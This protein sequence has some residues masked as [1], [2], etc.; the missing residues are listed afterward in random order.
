MANAVEEHEAA[1]VPPSS[2]AP[3][4][5]V[6]IDEVPTEPATSPRSQVVEVPVHPRY[7]EE[8]RLPSREYGPH[9]EPER[10]VTRWISRE[11]ETQEEWD[12][13]FRKFRQAWSNEDMERERQQAEAAEY[14]AHQRSIQ[15]WEAKVKARELD[16][17]A[18][19]CGPTP[20]GTSSMRALPNVHEALRQNDPKMTSYSQP[21]VKKAPPTLG[22]ARPSAFYSDAEPPRIGAPVQPPPPA[23]PRPVVAP[24]V[25][26]P[27]A[28]TP[29]T[30][31]HPP[32]P[33]L[34]ALPKYS[35]METSSCANKHPLEPPTAQAP[36]SKHVRCKAYP[37][38]S[39]PPDQVY[40]A[41]SATV[42]MP[43]PSRPCP[44]GPPAEFMPTPPEVASMQPKASTDE[45]RSR[46]NDQGMYLRVKSVRDIDW[47][48]P[49]WEQLAPVLKGGPDPTKSQADLCALRA[50]VPE[51]TNY[52][53][54]G[55]FPADNV[56]TAVQK[57]HGVHKI[58]MREAAA[59]V[60]N[61]T[62]WFSVLQQPMMIIVWCHDWEDASKFQYLMQILQAQFGDYVPRY[63]IFMFD[64][65]KV[66]GP[67]TQ[68]QEPTTV[69]DGTPVIGFMAE[70]FLDD[71]STIG[72]KDFNPMWTFPTTSVNQCWDALTFGMPPW[73]VGK[74]AD[75]NKLKAKEA[76]QSQSPIAAFKACNMLQALGIAYSKIVLPSGDS[77]G[78]AKKRTYCPTT[79]THC[80]QWEYAS[81]Y[82]DQLR[83]ADASPL[84]CKE[85]T[86]LVRIQLSK[87]SQ[88]HPDCAFADCAS[89]TMCGAMISLTPCIAPTVPRK[90]DLD[91]SVSFKDANDMIYQLNTILSKP[92]D[93]PPIPVP[94]DDC[95]IFHAK[96]GERH[97][98]MVICPE[99]DCEWVAYMTDL[100][101]S[102][103][104]A[105]GVHEHALWSTRF[106]EYK[107]WQQQNNKGSKSSKQA[108]TW[109]G[110]S[111]DKWS[112]T[113]TRGSSKRGQ[114]VPVDLSKRTNPEEKGLPWR[115]LDE[116]DT[117]EDYLFPETSLPCPVEKQLPLPAAQQEHTLLQQTSDHRFLPAPSG[118]STW[119]C[120]PSAGSL[121]APRHQPRLKI[122]IAVFAR[123][124][125]FWRV[126]AR[127]TS[128]I[129]SKSRLFS[130][131]ISLLQKRD[132][133]LKCYFSSNIWAP[134]K[135]ICLFVGAA[136]S[137]VFMLSLPTFFVCL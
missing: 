129:L 24:S 112:T 65:S 70:T 14:E 25:D 51:L 20:E 98:Q 105:L 94:R 7:I 23:A 69:W 60:L 35:S 90:C 84:L 77:K 86:L 11:G 29:M 76:L 72:F 97:R 111:S 53:F 125:C 124:F 121:P 126:F 71:L 131:V 93:F 58:H 63:Q 46:M 31:G 2:E 135:K 104:E 117:S 85:T 83:Q 30:P 16:N 136:L 91:A 57:S 128:P 52:L 27:L 15:E 22:R 74:N 99:Q 123:F 78:E 44:K 18:L 133:L 100:D 64:D 79:W 1:Q 19:P 89:T 10:F 113:S 95:H 5:A 115:Q 106:Q 120:L 134:P 55:I 80:Y 66:Y 42:E 82:A 114:S 38:P 34:E 48:R 21:V 26:L 12:D 36:P 47:S 119:R 6:P 68:W 41:A 122:P 103:V 8:L 110:S 54:D 130:S 17:A 32:R 81:Q 88:T 67:C 56:I 96:P 33:P 62:H 9:P 43:Q 49:L 73:H 13:Y 102:M 137:M 118:M 132:S 101:T 45:R 40:V 39:Q 109:E 61:G 108:W 59:W 4:P 87:K 127:S 50:K 92:K 28:V 37:Y 116:V 3:V 107:E 75:V